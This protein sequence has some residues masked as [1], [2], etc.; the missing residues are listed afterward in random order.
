M[1]NKQTNEPWVSHAAGVIVG[2][3]IWSETQVQSSGGGGFVGKHGGYVEAPKVSSTVTKQLEFFLKEPE[4][5]EHR[6]NLQ[7]VD[8]SVRDGNRVIAVWG[9]PTGEDRGPYCHVENL[10]TGEIYQ[11]KPKVVPDYSGLTSGTKVFWLGLLLSLAAMFFGMLFGSTIGR[12]STSPIATFLVFG[13]VFG[14]PALAFVYWVVHCYK[15]DQRAEK[16]GLPAHNSFMQLVAEA[17][18][19]ARATLAVMP[20]P[21]AS[22]AL[23][24][25]SDTAVP[26]EHF[27][28]A[29]GAKNDAGNNF[30]RACG[31]PL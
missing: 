28:G 5:K 30:C 29:C 11:S 13:M 19:K 25:G 4:G 20:A 6:I 24:R 1:T 12:S 10:D 27:C 14:I 9:S 2:S 31:K 18:E 21:T 16:Q 23:A 7:N 17:I 26:S 8:F 3:K 22:P 15:N